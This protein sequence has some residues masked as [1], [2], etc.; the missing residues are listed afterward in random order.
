MNKQEKEN[1]L[2]Q[3]KSLYDGYVTRDN[4]T[5]NQTP[6]YVQ[7]LAND[8]NGI[9]INNKGVV[10]HYMNVGINENLLDMIADGPRDLKNGTVDFDSLP[11]MSDINIELM[12]DKYPSPNEDE[13]EFVTYGKI[14]DDPEESMMAMKNLDDF[15]YDIDQLEDYSNSD[16]Y[17]DNSEE[18]EE[19]LTYGERI[20]DTLQNVDEEIIPDLVHQ[21]YESMH[22]FE[23][24]K[25]Y[26]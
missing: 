22:M 13:E 3:H 21:L 8:K 7:D 18:E 5:S 16:Y 11:E 26:N 1:I 4:T 12:H 15:E 23:R 6:L 9:T 10:K 14:S 20:E 17:D 19:D 2:D 25:K 24:F